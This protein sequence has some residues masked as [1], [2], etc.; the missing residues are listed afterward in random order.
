MTDFALNQIEV[1]HDEAAHRF[2]AVVQGL[3]AVL[4]YK[5][6]PGRML[7]QHTEVP[8][9]LEG[10]GIAA[11]MTRVALEYARSNKL[12]VVPACSYTATFMAKHPEYNDLLPPPR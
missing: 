12:E 11:K 2:E 10:R 1:K 7:I 8:Q 6:V 3:S 5:I 4:I 9:E